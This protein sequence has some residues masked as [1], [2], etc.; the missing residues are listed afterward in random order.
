MLDVCLLF[1]EN[2]LYMVFAAKPFI[3]KKFLLRLLY[4]LLSLLETQFDNG[5]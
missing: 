1:V 3:E 5:T 2:G 4:K